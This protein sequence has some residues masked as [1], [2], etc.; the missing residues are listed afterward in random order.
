MELSLKDD[1]I[2]KIIELKFTIESNIR[3]ITILFDNIIRNNSI[4]MTN[5]LDIIPNIIEYNDKIKHIKTLSLELQETML[6]SV[7]NILFK[8]CQHIW[9]DDTIEDVFERE[10]HIC[11]CNKCFIY[12]K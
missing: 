7:E 11:Y 6:L 3:S 10:K 5:N 4:N 12:K 8:S 2:D 1:E 9:I